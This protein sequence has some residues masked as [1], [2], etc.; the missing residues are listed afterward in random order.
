MRTKATTPPTTPPAIA[1]VFDFDGFVAAGLELDVFTGEDD[2]GDEVLVLEADD[3]DT[4]HD[5]LSI[6]Y[7]FLKVN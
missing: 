2:V 1:P 6:W 4:V 3:F 7:H 5:V